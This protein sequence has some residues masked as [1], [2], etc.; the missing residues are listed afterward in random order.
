[1][2]IG[3]LGWA[4]VDLDEELLESSDNDKKESKYKITNGKIVATGVR[5]FDEPVDRQ[6]KSLAAA[7]GVSRRSRAT[8]ERKAERLKYFIRLAKEY[9][10]IADT[11]TI[12]NLNVPKK[13]SI[14]DWDIW[15]L[16][17]DAI[18]KK[19]SPIEIFRILYHIANH[20]G[21]YFPTKAEASEL[22]NKKSNK[23]NGDDKEDKKAKAG[24]VAVKNAYKSSEC[25][26]IGEFIFQ[27][28]G[29]KHNKKMIIVSHYIEMIY[30]MRSKKYCKFNV[31]MEMI[32]LHRNLK[33]VISMKF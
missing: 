25:K 7:R 18:Y 6:G 8:T 10:I 9:G 1:M 27:K 13:V 19:L 15:K 16:R 20:R 24:I 11:F 17:A 23:S 4:V 3:S 30:V 33:L 32:Y 31:K 28:E 14:K 29:S 12:K 5:I 2:G 21:F 22:E 26:T